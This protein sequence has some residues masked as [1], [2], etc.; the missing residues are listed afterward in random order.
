MKS[1]ALLSVQ[2]SES[3]ANQT[4]LLHDYEQKVG[5]VVFSY[6]VNRVI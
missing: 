4:D 1:N 5:W 6:F 3:E 2:V